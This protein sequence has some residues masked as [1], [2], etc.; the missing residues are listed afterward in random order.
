MDMN[1]IYWHA[2]W[3][4]SI[5]AFRMILVITDKLREKGNE[6]PHPSRVMDTSKVK[7]PSQH[8]EHPVQIPPSS[9][10]PPSTPLSQILPSSVTSPSTFP[11]QIAPL[12]EKS[13]SSLS[14]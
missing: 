9:V 8:A 10:T 14:V 7:D 3:H 2:V 1:G 4:L 6:K 11:S 12:S 5:I 13:V